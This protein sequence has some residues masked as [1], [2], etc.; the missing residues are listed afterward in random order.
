VRKRNPE[1]AFLEDFWRISGG[2]LEDF[3]KIS[4]RFLVNLL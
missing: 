3:W 4:G 2:F 1:T